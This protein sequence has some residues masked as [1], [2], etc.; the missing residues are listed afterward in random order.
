MLIRGKGMKGKLPE[1]WYLLVLQTLQ[2]GSQGRGLVGKKGWEQE[3][4]CVAMLFAIA[5]LYIFLIHH[6]SQAV[7]ILWE[8]KNLLGNLP[9][10]KAAVVVSSNYYNTHYLGAISIPEGLRCAENVSQYLCV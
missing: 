3:L 9:K 8:T 1:N 6:Y 2:D 7:M 4:R 5:P 10:C